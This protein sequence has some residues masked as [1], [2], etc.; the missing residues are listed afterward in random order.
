MIIFEF[1]DYK[2]FV[3]TRIIA[4]PRKG[5]GEYQKI[6]EYLRVHATLISQIFKGPREL[7]LEQACEL[8]TYLSLNALETDYFITLV[9]FRRAGSLKL[10][11]IL[12]RRILSIKSSFEPKST[13]F[14]I[15]SVLIP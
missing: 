2:N 6:A 8:S 13:K 12:E 15:E 5:R 14:P 10:K 9:E 1:D 7:T 4:L 11:E 3:N